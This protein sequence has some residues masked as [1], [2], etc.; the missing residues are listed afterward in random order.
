MFYFLVLNL[1]LG[2]SGCLTRAFP[3]SSSRKKMFWKY[4]SFRSILQLYRLIF[5]YL[6]MSS[7]G[8]P[9]ARF[10]SCH[11]RSQ[12]P[13]YHFLIIC[14]HLSSLELIYEINIF[15]RSKLSAFP[16]SLV[17]FLNFSRNA[18]ADR[19]YFFCRSLFTTSYCHTSPACNLTTTSVA[20]HGNNVTR[21]DQAAHSFEIDQTKPIILP[22]FLRLQ[23]TCHY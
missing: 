15:V 16:D 6:L 13:V 3:R 14:M 21:R 12:F 1:L 5:F 8:F 20:S 9:T 22:Q 17:T 10:T 19:R 11:S 7:S 18:S 4:I 23:G 2:S